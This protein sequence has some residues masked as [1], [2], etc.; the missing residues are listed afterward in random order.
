MESNFYREEM[1]YAVYRGARHLF[2]PTLGHQPV[3][4]HNE[5]FMHLE[6]NENNEEKKV[7]F[8]NK[9]ERAHCPLFGNCLSNFFGVN[10][11]TFLRKKKNKW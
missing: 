7:L 9:T 4:T 2:L 1:E 11:C 3:S 8:S 5:D 10:K 6:Q